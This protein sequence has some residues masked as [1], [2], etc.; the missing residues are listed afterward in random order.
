MDSA[1][2]DLPKEISNSIK[3]CMTDYI[4][5]NQEQQIYKTTNRIVNQYYKKTS[6]VLWQFCSIKYSKNNFKPVNHLYIDTE[7]IWI[8]FASL[9][10]STYA[11]QKVDINDTQK[12][13]T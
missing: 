4:F 11:F 12:N 1:I 9:V 6:T 10:I 7:R 8:D 2:Q 13:Y 3:T 5:I